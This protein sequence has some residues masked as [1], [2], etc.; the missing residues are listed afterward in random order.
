MSDQYLAFMLGADG[1]TLAFLKEQDYPTYPATPHHN[2]ALPGA[3]TPPS[4]TSINGTTCVDV[5]AYRSGTILIAPSDPA[6]TYDLRVWEASR[7]GTFGT[8]LAD[9]ATSALAKMYLIDGLTITGLSGNQSRA[10]SLFQKDWIF[11]EIA[12][13]SA[14]NCTVQV[15]VAEYERGGS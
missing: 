4:G 3:F 8:G 2:A 1:G 15:G 11:V 12:N 10:I 14:G 6:A 9:G 5:R 13:L 7:G